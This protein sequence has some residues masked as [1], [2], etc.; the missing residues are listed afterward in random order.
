MVERVT[1]ICG[2]LGLDCSSTP[3]RGGG[4]PILE[5]GRLFQNC[6]AKFAQDLPP[7][8]FWGLPRPGLIMLEGHVRAMVSQIK[9]PLGRLGA[10]L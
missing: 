6:L 8:D 1:I 10:A 2:A 5:K 3:L 9:N 4:K 7:V